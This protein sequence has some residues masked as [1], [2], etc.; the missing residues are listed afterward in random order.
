MAFFLETEFW[1][2]Y[3]QDQSAPMWTLDPTRGMSKGVL[4]NGNT[5]VFYMQVLWHMCCLNK[6]TKGLFHP[7]KARILSIMEEIS[8]GSCRCK[9]KAEDE[10]IS[11]ATVALVWPACAWARSAQTF[12]DV[13]FKLRALVAPREKVARLDDLHDEYLK[14]SGL[15]PKDVLD[16]KHSAMDDSERALYAAIKRYLYSL[17]YWRGRHLR[18]QWRHGDPHCLWSKPKP[19]FFQEHFI[20]L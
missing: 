1:R 11:I 19:P 5:C 8:L 20:F 14:V 18:P 4:V 13:A 10:L 9:N 7:A 3:V 2:D 12:A 17:L 6:A 15:F 16:K